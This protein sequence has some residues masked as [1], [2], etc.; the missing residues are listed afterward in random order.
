MC[1]LKQTCEKKL[2]NVHYS[3]FVI[4]PYL[5]SSD[6]ILLEKQLHWSLRSKCYPA[7]MSFRKLNKGNLMCSFLCK[8]EETLREATRDKKQFDFGFLLKGGVQPES[9]AFEELFKEPFF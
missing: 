7:K 5:I 6:L 2:R 4:K 8:S 9:K 3:E 1:K